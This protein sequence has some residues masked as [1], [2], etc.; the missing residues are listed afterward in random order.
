MN[1]NGLSL[2]HAFRSS[3]NLLRATPPLAISNYAKT[4]LIDFIKTIDR[5]PQTKKQRLLP[6]M[7]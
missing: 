3:A 5:A 6:A 1:P 4:I 7:M 2:R